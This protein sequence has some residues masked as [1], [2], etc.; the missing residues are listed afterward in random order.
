MENNYDQIEE[1]LKEIDQILYSIKI[2]ESAKEILERTPLPLLEYEEW[3]QSYRTIY[4]KTYFDSW[5]FNVGSSL[6]DYIKINM[7]KLTF[8]YII[9]NIFFF[10]SEVEQ[11]SAKFNLTY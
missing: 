1:N 5:L 9:L 8:Y 2:E 11:N 3:Y 10:K 4:S 6:S 7:M